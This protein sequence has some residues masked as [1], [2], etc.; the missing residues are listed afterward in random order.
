MAGPPQYAAAPPTAS[1]EVCLLKRLCLLCAVC[2]CPLKVCA[3]Y[4]RCMYVHPKFVPVMCGVC[5]STQ[6]SC[7]LRAVYVCPPKGRACYVR[8]MYAHSKVVPVMCGVCM[9]T[10]RSCLLCAVYVCPATQSH[11]VKCVCT[12][13][14]VQSLSVYTMDSAVSESFSRLQSNTTYQSRLLFCL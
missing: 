1:P 6:S 5:M 11:F 13:L 2:V 9:P 4:V 8:C 12:C 3:C 14:L 7:L 10:Q